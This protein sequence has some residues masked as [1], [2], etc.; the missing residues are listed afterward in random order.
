M[1]ACFQAIRTFLDLSAQS[2]HFGFVHFIAL[3]QKSEAFAH[4]FAGRIVKAAF[5][6]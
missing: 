3:L 1:T 6:L 2:V 5:D 4:D